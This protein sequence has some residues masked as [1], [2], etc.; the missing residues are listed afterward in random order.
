MHGHKNYQPGGRRIRKVAAGQARTAGVIL[1]RCAASKV[2]GNFTGRW[3]ADAG[4][5][6]PVSREPGGSTSTRSLKG[7]DPQRGFGM[8]LQKRTSDHLDGIRRRLSGGKGGSL[9]AIPFS[10]SSHHPRLGYRMACVAHLAASAAAWLASWRSRCL[11]CSNGAGTKAATGD[12]ESPALRG[13]RGAG[14][15]KLLAFG[16][17]ASRTSVPRHHLMMLVVGGLGRV[18]SS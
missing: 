12:A 14:D 18:G 5:A 16:A 10:I 6:T 1:E 3:R 4:P 15:S 8:F 7:A 9:P 2:G 13:S 17:R 11:D